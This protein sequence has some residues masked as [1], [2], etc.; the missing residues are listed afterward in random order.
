MNSSDCCIIK[1]RGREEEEKKTDREERE[2]YLKERQ[3]ERLTNGESMKVG[4]S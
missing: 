2:K 4:S 1:E 3:L